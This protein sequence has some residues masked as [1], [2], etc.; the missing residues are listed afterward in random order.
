MVDFNLNNIVYKSLGWGKKP[1]LKDITKYHQAAA[2]TRYV[3][4]GLFE[5]MKTIHEET[6]NTW[7]EFLPKF[8]PHI[9][10]WQEPLYTHCIGKSHFQ[11]KIL[12]LDGNYIKV[13]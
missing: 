11:F 3:A 12:P 9:F 8:I 7:Y 2:N 10:G 4:A 5:L 6:T 1:S 13:S